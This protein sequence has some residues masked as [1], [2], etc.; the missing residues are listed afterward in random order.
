MPTEAPA[1]AACLLLKIALCRA[2]IYHVREFFRILLG[3]E[4]SLA[5][6]R[7]RVVTETEKTSNPRTSH[8]LPVV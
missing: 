3:W 4:P 2:L 8:N 7:R 1:E 5:F 6:L